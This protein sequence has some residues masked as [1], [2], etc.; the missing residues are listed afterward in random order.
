MI[1]ACKA[2]NLKALNALV[3]PRSLIFQCKINYYFLM[4]RYF[5]KK[6]LISSTTAGVVKPNFS[7]R[8]L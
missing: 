4:K 2:V 5:T 8:T 6:S 1:I 7:S 3:L